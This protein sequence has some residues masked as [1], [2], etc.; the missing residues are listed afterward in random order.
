[1]INDSHWNFDNTYKF[2]N[3]KYAYSGWLLPVGI[4]QKLYFRVGRAKVW[5]HRGHII[6]EVAFEIFHAFSSLE[7]TL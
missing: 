5:S 7:V 6:F 1:M 3:E 2:L 4:V